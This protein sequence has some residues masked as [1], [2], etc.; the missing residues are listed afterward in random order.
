MSFPDVLQ[1]GLDFLSAYPRDSPVWNPLS[2]ATCFSVVALSKLFVYTA[3]K[4]KIFNLDRLDAAL[5]RSKLE[6]R[7]LL[8]VMNHMSVVDDP[9]LWGVLPFKY[10]FRVD[11]IR[12]GFGAQNV[13]FTNKFLQYF[14]S[15]GKVLE[16][17]RFGAGPFQGLV[18]AAIR[19]LS[20]DD[21]MILELFN[22]STQAKLLETSH[23]D[24]KLGKT[25]ELSRSL[26]DQGNLPVL[27]S[28][29]SWFHV[30]PEGFVLQL[31]PPHANS[32]RYFRWGV[33]RLVLE[34]TKAPIVLPIF[35]TGFEKVAPELAAELPIQRYLPRNFR[36]EINIIFGEPIDDSIIEGFR[37]EWRAL[38]DKY[39]DPNNPLDLSN[40]LKTSPEAQDLRSR[41]AATIREA[42]ADI[43]HK[44][45]GLPPEDERLKL[46]EFWKRYT[47]T[48]GKS[49]PD[50]R[51]IGK[52]WAIRRLQKFLEEQD[53][54][55]E[56]STAAKEDND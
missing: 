13:C 52:N 40:Q 5:E 44:E 28:S 49:D 25:L 3:Y 17:R 47:Q 2:Q 15:L 41:V 12:W 6:N 7:G 45:A 21:T 1:R 27:R 55:E 42:V 16:T 51:F 43:R 22:E 14:F 9:F 23:T 31:E 53:P 32:M 37:D 54:A 30:F 29:P 18:D 24:S 34:A 36:H 33:S 11:S 39:Y 35:T 10:Y 8:T 48:E 26:R 4:P 38:V 46:V 19:L 56:A 50:I 20:P